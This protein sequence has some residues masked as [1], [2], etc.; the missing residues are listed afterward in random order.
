MQVGVE[1]SRSDGGPLEFASVMGD[2]AVFSVSREIPPVS[3]GRCQVEQVI[4][5][6]RLPCATPPTC[7]VDG[8]A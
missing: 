3:T 4:L 5:A 7:V 1:L 8:V 2:P 6:S